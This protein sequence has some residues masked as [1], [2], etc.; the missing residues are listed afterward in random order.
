MA[1]KNVNLRPGAVVQ[2]DAMIAGRTI[3]IQGKIVHDLKMAARE[4]RMAAEVGGSVD[5]RVEK[6]VLLPGALVHG[7]LIVH[8]PLAPEISPQ[9]QVLGR[10]EH[11]PTARERWWEDW[12][13]QWIF[14]FLALTVLG[15]AAISLSQL[16][17]NRVA[18]TFAAKPGRALIVG[19]LG[20]ILIPLIALLLL[21]TVI[22]LPL[23][24][25]TLA[26]YVIALLLSGVFA[27]WLAGGWLLDRFNRPA[28]SRWTRIVVGS[29]AVSFSVSLPWVGGLFWLAVLVSGLGALLLERRDF[30]LNQAH[31]QTA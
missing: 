24:F 15:I 20:L 26:L 17:T 19:L 14:S 5:A 11:I 9:A 3:E 4:A 22:G 10:L 12:L 28:A 1:G 2:H 27:S 13:S 29:L 18:T 6:L 30:M 7:N 8:S 23:A 21:I 16:W 25:I 31:Q